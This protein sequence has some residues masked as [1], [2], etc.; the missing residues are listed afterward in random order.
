VNAARPYPSPDAPSAAV[1]WTRPAALAFLTAFVT[2]C[3]QVLVHRM[4]SVKLVNNYAFLVISL[5]MLGFAVSGVLLV[6]WLPRALAR[7]D[8][9]A[10]A[11][12]AASALSFLAACALFYAAPAGAQWA[13]SRGD[14]VVSFLR[15]VP[16][17][18]VFAVPFTFCGLVLGALLSHPA[19]PTRTVYCFDLVG[20]AAGAFAI[21]PAIGLFGVEGAALLACA[22]WLA[23]SMLLAWP[24]GRPARALAVGAAVALAGVA[25]AGPDRVF[26][27]R[28]PA[29]SVLSATQDPGSGYVLEHVA[30]DAIARIE[31]TRMPPPDPEALLWPALLGD[32]RAFLDRFERVLTQNNNAFTYAV[33]YDGS[34]ASLRGIDRTLYAAAYRA[35]SVPRPRVL[36]IGVGG[37]FD[38]LTA[39]FFEAS[40][41]TAVEV[42]AASVDIVRHTYRDYFRRWVEDPR[43]ELVQGEGRHVLSTRPGLF[44]V[45]QLSGVDSVSGTPAAAH[46]FSENYLYSSEAFDLFLSRLTPDGVI[47]MMRQEYRPP[48][49]MLKA[50]VTAV[51]A[52][53][54]AGVAHP[55]DHIMTVTAT[56]GLFT[57]LLVKKTPFSPDEEQR[58]TDWA[59][60]N[61]YFAVSAS[62]RLAGPPSAYRSFLALDDPAR[63]AAFARLYPFD[64]RPAQDDRPFFF[65]F[66]YWSHLFSRDPVV[67]ASVP[68]MDYGLLL[69]FVTTGLA[70]AACVFLPLRRLA[71]RG[72]RAPGAG[73]YA[74]YFAAIGVGYMAIEMA[75]IQK[76]G[77]FMGHPNYALSVV[78][79]ALLLATGL[80]ALLSARIVRVLGR[81]RF[82][83]YPLA[84]IVLAEHLLVLPR[85][86]ALVGL[87]FAARVAI[88]FALVLPIGVCLGTFFPAG[89]DRLKESASAFVPWAWGVNGVFSVVAP[90][91]SVAVSMT[92]GISA[93]LLSAVPLYLAAGLLLPDADAAAPGQAVPTVR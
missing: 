21:I 53:R 77:L 32:D 70:A 49:E 50:L 63:E 23:G 86:S 52:L 61:P 65:R 83:A 73:R 6:R 20:S 25:A 41:V 1:P 42:N 33:N 26:R 45:V 92:W 84:A 13:S 72:L 31:L 62:P 34:R 93:L 3:L 39:L 12:A 11:C 38:V 4:V 16:L 80:G 68:I 28:Y 89:L 22:G 60:A 40:R 17:A 81:Q 64:V 19:L 71:A 79:A 18:L 2:L 59:G 5:T 43:V 58:L 67:L 91:V 76:F 48:R 46:V 15:S 24:R 8:D 55:R 74:G 88:V 75:L 47:N 82:V 66:S 37:G 29:G 87:P 54:R 27:M 90:I 9:F 14:F 69:L 57:A 7:L 56:N 36:V 78:L 51:A 85:L 44:D 35:S 10:T 30:W